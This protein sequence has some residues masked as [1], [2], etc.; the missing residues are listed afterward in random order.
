MMVV[1]RNRIAKNVRLE[2]YHTNTHKFNEHPIENTAVFRA[3]R[4]HSLFKTIKIKKADLVGMSYNLG[5]IPLFYWEYRHD[6]KVPRVVIKDHDLDAPQKYPQARIDAIVKQFIPV[7]LTTKKHLLKIKEG[8][9]LTIEDIQADYP[10][11]LTVAMEK[12]KPG[13]TRSDEWFADRMI[14]GMYANTLDKDP[15]NSNLGISLMRLSDI[16]GQT[17]SNMTT[18]V[19]FAMLL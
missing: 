9:K 10:E 4:L 5:T 3:E 18:L 19:K 13:I 11:N 8:K 16:F 7:E 17:P 14:N 1:H 2:I 6:T 15:E 12:I